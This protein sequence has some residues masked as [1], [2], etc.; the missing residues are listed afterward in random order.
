MI[1]LHEI[2]ELYNTLDLYLVS[3]RVEG[4]PRSIF[5]ASMSKTPIIST[6]VGIA[7]ELLPKKSIYD[8]NNYLTYK[9]ALSDIEKSYDNV[10]KLTIE[11][12]HIE[13][14]YDE[15]MKFCCYKKNKVF[16][17]FR[18]EDVAYGGGNIFTYN[19]VNYLRNNNICVEYN[20]N[21]FIGIFLIIDPFPGRYK[22][23]GLKDIID[24]KLK[25]KLNSKIVIRVNDCDV[26]RSNVKPENSRELCISKNYKKIDYLIFNSDFIKEYYLKKYP[27]MKGIDNCV[28]YNGGNSQIFYPMKQMTLSHKEKIKIVTHH[29]SDNINKG[30]DIYYRLWKYSMRKN[31]GIEFVFIGRK[32]NDKFKNEVPV[33]GPYKGKQLADELRKCHIYITASIN[34]SCPN[35]VI[36]GLLCGLP[37]LY[38]DHEGGGKNLCELITSKKIGEK[39]NN[40]VE[41]INAIHMIRKHYKSYKSNILD[42]IELFENNICYNKYLEQFQNLI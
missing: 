1:S 34:D 22:K 5:E 2:N 10:K 18:P 41:L 23:Y 20:L 7:S 16:I 28:I 40:F 32:F 38:I 8:M 13:N 42:N 30:Y 4:G 21:S 19:M 11:N 31:S 26:I 36:E 17:N 29:W 27:V 12:G 39:F 6:D 24:F 3:A 37:V 9:N 33:V 25:N 14:F 35:H 15:F